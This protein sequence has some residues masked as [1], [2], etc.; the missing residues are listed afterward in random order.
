MTAVRHHR[1]EP[2]GV[3]GYPITHPIVGQTD[4]Y[5]K[6]KAW[7]PLVAED[8]F[9]HVFA[10]VAPWGVGKSRLGYEI[11]AQVNDASSGWKVRGPSGELVDARLFDRDRDREKHLALYIRYSQVADRLLNLDN[12]FAPAVYKALAPLAR[13][14]F[15]RSIQHQIAKEAH[16]RLFVDG[17]EPTRLAEAMELDQHGDAIYTD[18]ELATR[19]CNGAF[20]VL[21]QYGIAKVIVV[22]DELETAAERA[23]GGI[24]AEEAKAMDGRAIT[25]RSKAGTEADARAR[26]PW[27]R[28]VA[29]CSPAIGD[30]L[31]EVQSTDR[32]F[33]I[34]D[35][36]RNAFS[37]VSA[38][39]QSLEAEGRLLRSYPSGLVEAAYM[40]SGANFGWFN[41][42]MA[43][44]DQVLQQSTARDASDLAH[45]FARAIQIQ[46][47]IGRYVLDHRALDET[48]LS[49][50][51]QDALARLLFGQ[52]PVPLGD[53]A[54]Q[55]Q[56][57]LDARNLHGERVALRFH[58][59]HWSRQAC[60]QELVRSRFTRLGGTGRYQAPG[61]PEAIELDRMLDDLSTLAVHDARGAG[62]GEVSLLVPST[63]AD[64]L[65]LVDLVHPH[66]AAEETARTL[67]MAFHGAGDLP[68][69][70][71]T[72]IGP[73][74]E[75]LRR[76]DIRLRKA[77][78]GTML[79]L[80]DE[81]AA[82]TAFLDVDRPTAEHRVQRV[83]TGAMRVL[84]RN[85]QYDAEPAGLGD[86]VA[87]IR[88]TKPGLVDLKGLWLH[89]KGQA[90]FAW[91]AN[92]QQ[93]VELAT[94]VGRHHRDQGR[95]PVVAFTTDFGLPERFETGS[96]A[97]FVKAR[98]SIVL[99]H[100]NSGEEAALASVGIATAQQAGF[101]L[102]ADGF[103]TRFA[104]RLNRIRGPVVQRIQTWRHARSAAGQ[105]AW[106]L[107][108]SGTLKDDARRMLVDAWMVARLDHDG[109]PLSALGP[110]AG[111][112]LAAVLAELQKLGLSPA[113]APNGYGPADVAG[114]WS[115]D[116]VD[117]K[118][119]V[120]PFLLGSVVLPLVNQPTL[121]LDIKSARN[122]WFWGYTWDG[123]RD[124]DI[125]REWLSTA[126]EM[127]WAEAEEVGKRKVQHSYVTVESIEAR[128]VAAE[129]WLNDD[130]PR[131]VQGLED[132]FGTARVRH[133][134][135]PKTGLRTRV[136]REALKT[137][138]K[139][140]A[141]LKGLSAK[142]PATPNAEAEQWF[143]A[144][145]RLRRSIVGAVRR[146]YDRQG[147]DE[148][149]F[150]PG[151][152]SIRLEEPDAP[153][154]LTIGRAARF[155]DVVR[156]VAK[157]IRKRIP[158]VAEHVRVEARDA[159]GFP[160]QLFS[161]PLS[162]LESIVDAGMTG[163]DPASTTEREQHIQPQ[164]LAF[165]L[166]DLQV[167]EAHKQL[168]RLGREVGVDLDG[169]RVHVVGLE[170]IDGDLVSGFRDLLE[171]YA[172]ARK[173]ATG[174]AGRIHALEDAMSDAP[175]DFKPP[176][177]TTLSAIRDMPRLIEGQL[178]ESVDD[179]VEDLLDD[180]NRT[181]NLGRFK[182]LMKEANATLLL[183]PESALQSLEGKVRTLENTVS[184]YRQRLIE[185]PDLA[186]HRAGL[187]A[188]LRA[189]AQTEKALP[190]RADV[191]ARSLRE[192]RIYIDGLQVA[193]QREGTALL[194]PADVLFSS[195]LDAMARVQRQE[196]PGLSGEQVDGLVREGF[197]R[198]VYALGG[199]L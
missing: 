80:A 78:V 90:A 76:L 156:K 125:Y 145:T 170:A 117:A 165:F 129:N 66:P 118:P 38:F 137:A 54:A 122:V 163:E 155:A 41:V 8:R 48:E 73:S 135:H 5:N 86:A 62:P 152:T 184:A 130:F 68:P 188:L 150:D 57:L 148:V 168:Q 128:L 160:V 25:R 69:E 123:N 102:R 110:D 153:L 56:A 183:E 13:G 178:N 109:K 108:P 10:V 72:H 33:E 139:Q 101:R 42:I 114:L 164:T 12:W 52:Q 11:V 133:H 39:V 138:K 50:D 104:E 53:V 94:A 96:L 115:G 161:R 126:V 172:T 119:T 14:R 177:G 23:S 132:L 196:D 84:D 141:E 29:L 55:A 149:D 91:V 44:V 88:T 131:I 182:P 81:N 21:Q 83:L 65:Q 27:L 43:V 162:K 111:I 173:K 77:S 95:T 195:W 159:H 59:A 197:L 7:L 92:D 112:D 17:F 99:V 22:L 63:L 176:A 46:E 105:I 151:T 24:E 146:V 47:R 191:D 124:S 190:T 32:R 26:F 30:E 121:A 61:I 67:W 74:V 103:T 58:G 36:A 194:K 15:D 85:W 20:A 147:Y 40:M 18:T 1:W 106:P 192:G 4:F 16:D 98:Q 2:T 70:S 175:A 136:A 169:S 199:G 60:M 113:A 127:G 174:L 187:N 134:F 97:Q 116:D 143:I 107:R 140:L 167:Q 166:R 93:L 9:A 198:R 144:C 3:T 35:L 79:R 180:H 28:F 189:K 154:W 37:D 49:G 64:F 185:D 120:P 186:A 100:L 171:R 71:A 75:M 158:Q 45:V 181:M 193:W 51:L 179:Q 31:K 142:P 19:L 87:A 157:S 34:V 82:F 89:P 6:F